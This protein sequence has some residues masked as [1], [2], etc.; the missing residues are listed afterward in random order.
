MPPCAAIC[1]PI[2][3]TII[4]R[5]AAS[6]V[7]AAE[8]RMRHIDRLEHRLQQLAD[9]HRLEIAAPPARSSPSAPAAGVLAAGMDR[10]RSSAH[11]QVGLQRAGGLD[12]LQDAD[13]VARA[14]A[15]RVQA[16]HQVA[17]RHAALQD[18]E[19]AVVL[20]VDLDLGAR[21]DD[22]GAVGERRRAG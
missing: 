4:G 13:Q 1:L 14:D 17:Q 6:A 10:R 16:G 7:A 21:H 2:A 19:L 18:A 9:R 15:E 22:G 5:Q 8:R 3:S 20:V 12:R 11:H